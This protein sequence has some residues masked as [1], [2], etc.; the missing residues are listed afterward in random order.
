MEG[1]PAPAGEALPSGS[2]EREGPDLPGDGP[3]A[4]EAAEEEEQEE[5][6]HPN[7]EYGEEYDSS[8]PEFQARFM[9]PGSPGRKLLGIP[10]YRPSQRRN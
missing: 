4:A 9:R 1:A 7:Y 8:H 2:D 10:A 3:P 5:E 6:E